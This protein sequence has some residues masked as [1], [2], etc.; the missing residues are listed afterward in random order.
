VDVTAE[1]S[2]HASTQTF[3]VSIH[4]T[5]TPY[6]GFRFTTSSDP[7]LSDQQIVLLL[8]GESPDV[9]TE[10]REE[11]ALQ[12]PQQLQE[13]MLQAFGARLLTAPITGRVESVVERATL[14]D[15]VLVS[16][17]LGTELNPSAKLTLGKRI[18][19]KVFLT[20]SRTLST[21]ATDDGRLIG[22]ASSRNLL[23]ATRIVYAW[24]SG[25]G[26]SSDACVPFVAFVWCWPSRSARGL[27]AQTADRPPDGR[28]S[29]TLD[30]IGRPRRRRTCS[31]ASTS[32]PV[33]RSRSKRADEHRK[34]VSLGPFDAVEVSV[35]DTPA[36]IASSSKRRRAIRSRVVFNGM[37][38][39]RRRISSAARALLWAAHQHVA[40]HRRGHDRVAARRR[41]L[42]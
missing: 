36:G 32:R 22:T 5:G 38:G 14:L 19:S 4:L 21:S 16:P 9:G 34:L 6:G 41:G 27:R 17:T 15:S 28:G 39:C 40:R 26:T 29:I 35:N 42:P 10:A 25:S 24:I 30:I 7:W 31:R 2:P 23:S 18:S 33:T 8:L 1:V 11:R 37:T 12:S 20:Y 13:Q 3:N